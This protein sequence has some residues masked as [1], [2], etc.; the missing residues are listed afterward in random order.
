MKRL[1][2]IFGAVLLLAGCGKAITLTN[3]DTGDVLK[4]RY[5]SAN[6]TVTVTMPDGQV[7]SG[8]YSAISG[9]SMTFGNAYVFSGASTATAFGTGMAV[10]GASNAYA[11]LVSDTSSLAMEIIV[12]YSEWTGH[13][14]GEARTNDGR[15]FKVQF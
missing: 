14:Y 8:R 1:L 3:F 6:R 12:S 7:L 2:I 5:N 13:G 9:A 4:G 10:G 11:L 15:A